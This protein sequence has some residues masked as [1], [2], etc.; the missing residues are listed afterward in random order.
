MQM[1]WLVLPMRYATIVPQYV[2][3]GLLSTDLDVDFLMN[4]N[5]MWC[6]SRF[7]ISD[8]NA[9]HNKV[10]AKCP[11]NAHVSLVH[12]MMRMSDWEYAYDVNALL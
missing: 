2:I 3:D 4:A 12:A 7:F 11:Y 6:K 5:K 1:P 8:A 10:D 9:F